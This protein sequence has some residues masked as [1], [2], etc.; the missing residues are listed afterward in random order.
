MNREARAGM[1]ALSHL[2]MLS[3][4]VTE[5]EAKACTSALSVSSLQNHDPHECVNVIHYLI[6]DILLHQKD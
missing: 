2:M 1:L 4:A 6:P 3:H 5:Q